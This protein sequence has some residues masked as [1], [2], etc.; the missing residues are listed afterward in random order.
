MA[1][2]II[3]VALAVDLAELLSAEWQINSHCNRRAAYCD[4][5]PRLGADD[6][7]DVDHR[8]PLTWATP[9]LDPAP[10]CGPGPE[11]VDLVDLVDVVSGQCIGTVRGF[12]VE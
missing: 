2:R 5:R 12:F 8:L 1:S 6:F 11:L 4:I 10:L 9:L 7:A 3:T